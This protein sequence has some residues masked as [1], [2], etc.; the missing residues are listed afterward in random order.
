M[1]R[2]MNW[3]R[4]RMENRSIRQGSEL[5]G[6]ENT[7]V[8]TDGIPSVPQKQPRIA[9]MPPCSCGK[10]VGFRGA[11]KQDCK[12]R[13]GR[14]IEEARLRRTPRITSPAPTGETARTSDG[15]LTV[16][17]LVARFNRVGLNGI[18]RT[19]LKSVLSRLAVDCG[20]GP[21]DITSARQ[22]IEAMVA[23]IDRCG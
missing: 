5:V 12:L 9:P 23:D 2:R 8:E 14:V 19:F 4:V 10:P 20:S 11:H 13:K 3:D 17:E 16:S 7:G 21:Y 15:S 6:S 18:L 1:A 22:M